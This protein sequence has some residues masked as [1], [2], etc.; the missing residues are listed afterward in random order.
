MVSPT[1]IADAAR[2]Y[3]AAR[4]TVPSDELGEA[5][6]V[7]DGTFTRSHRLSRRGVRHIVDGCLRAANIKRPQVSNHGTGHSAMLAYR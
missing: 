6:I 3:L 2:A 5:V 7:A 1:D 4:G